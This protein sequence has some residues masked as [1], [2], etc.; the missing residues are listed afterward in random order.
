MF[1]SLQMANPGR[2]LDLAVDKLQ[3]PFIELLKEMI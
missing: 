2:W 1:C 3:K